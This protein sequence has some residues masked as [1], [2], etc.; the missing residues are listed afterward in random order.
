M[1]IECWKICFFS[2]Q[3]SRPKQFSIAS[4]MSKRLA[5]RSRRTWVSTRLNCAWQRSSHSRIGNPWSAGFWIAWKTSS[6]AP[7][8]FSHPIMF[9]S[10]GR[11]RVTSWI[12][13]V[14]FIWS[15][16]ITTG[17]KSRRRATGLSVCWSKWETGWRRSKAGGDA[18]WIRWSRGVEKGPVSSIVTVL[19]DIIKTVC[20]DCY[21]Y[22]FVRIFIY[23]VFQFLYRSTTL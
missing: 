22:K 8:R 17:E 16:S 9:W 19:R 7:K 11:I 5:G 14:A 20:R 6:T 2:A 4:K 23:L 10:F 21:Y 3:A 13:S 12:R 15:G 1:I 18:T